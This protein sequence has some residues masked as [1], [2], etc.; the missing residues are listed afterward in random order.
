MVGLEGDA[1]ICLGLCHA[2]V[3]ITIWSWCRNI[4][5]SNGLGEKNS[6]RG[7][8]RRSLF[9]IFSGLTF[10]IHPLRR[11]TFRGYLVTRFLSP[12]GRIYYLEWLEK[13]KCK[14][15][16][17]SLKLQHVR[18]VEMEYSSVDPP[19]LIRFSI[20]RRVV[21]DGSCASAWNRR[22]RA[23][24]TFCRRSLWI[25]CENDIRVFIFVRGMILFSYFG[26]TST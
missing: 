18:R 10:F 24:R 26:V 3:T 22:T 14:N 8:L 12:P 7:D 21:V 20:T 15:K 6:L 17:Y 13:K 23:E 25:S 4:G 9:C 1:F 2:R 16:K 5:Q 11:L 19:L